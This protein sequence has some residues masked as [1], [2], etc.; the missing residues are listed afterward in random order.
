MKKEQ[1]E[2]I[3]R[4][5]HKIHYKDEKGVSYQIEDNPEKESHYRRKKGDKN[6]L[7][8]NIL[9]ENN[10]NIYKGLVIEV[11]RKS[12]KVLLLETNTLVDCVIGGNF[13]QKNE[14]IIATGDNV[15]I[16]KIPPASYVVR[17]VCPRSS[18]LSRPAAEGTKL[19]QVK[20]KII[21]ANI[22][23][24]CIVVS[25]ANPTFKPSLIDRYLL[26]ASKNNI[27]VVIIMN[28][29]DLVENRPES[30]EDYEKIGIKVAYTSTYTG[31]GITELKQAL[32]G[33]F[34]AFA[35]HSGVGKSALL[36]AMSNQLNLKTSEV[37]DGEHCWRH[38]TRKSTLYQLDNET[39]IIDTPG[40]RELGIWGIDA[41][42]VSWYFPEFH[43]PAEQCKFNDCTHDHE[44]GCQVKELVNAGLISAVRYNSYLRVR[45]SLKKENL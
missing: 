2:N 34:C 23:L 44:P 24:L 26:I 1:K 42:Q 32:Q 8:E 22:N 3:P 13:I 20:E 38:T 14:S 4:R 31:Q 40:I 17:H 27:P 9:L 35:G 5:K 37:G 36:N 29:M 7:T 43:E 19:K 6:I 18:K 33:N 11:S 45:D 25:T 12:T 21:A 30:I 16:E 39:F 28:K 10:P 15:F 41:A